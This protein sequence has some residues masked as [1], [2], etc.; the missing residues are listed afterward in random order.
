MNWKDYLTSKGFIYN[1]KKDSWIKGKGWGKSYSVSMIMKGLFEI[2]DA[3][4]VV[5]SD[6]V[7]SLEEF[8][9]LIKKYI[10]E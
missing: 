9:E 5:F 1:E 7:N 4:D 8:K 3:G 10:D 6:Y 2:K